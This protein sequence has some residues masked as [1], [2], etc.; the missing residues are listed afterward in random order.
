MKLLTEPIIR[1]LAANGLSQAAASGA[2]DLVPVVKLF[3]PDAGGTWLL[4]ESS[5]ADPDVLFGLCDLGM[6]FPELGHVSL[7]E[8][9]SIR[10]NMGLPVERDRFFEADAPISDYARMA[11][12]RGRIVC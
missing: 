7:R 10:G 9:M 5:P 6:G 3:T 4:T 11:W 2:L 12:E 8:L 1:K